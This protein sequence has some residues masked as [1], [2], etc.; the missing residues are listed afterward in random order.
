[1]SVFGQASPIAAIPPTNLDHSYTTSAVFV[2]PAMSGAGKACP[3]NISDGRQS[4]W[5]RLA[6]ASPVAGAGGL[7]TRDGF[8][9]GTSKTKAAAPRRWPTSPSSIDPVVDWLDI[10]SKTQFPSQRQ[11]SA[12]SSHTLARPVAVRA[13]LFKAFVVLLVNP[14]EAARNCG[15][16]EA[17][18]D[19]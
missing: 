19:N 8:W 12:V 5:R 16:R 13:L 2:G 18:D 10:V 4:R 11:M 15:C 6:V 9:R 3:R 17:R 1:M 14:V 7:Q